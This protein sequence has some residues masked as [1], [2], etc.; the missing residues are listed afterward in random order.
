MILAEEGVRALCPPIRRDEPAAADGCVAKLFPWFS[1]PSLVYILNIKVDIVITELYFLP[2][3]T[4]NG[5]GD[6]VVFFHTLRGGVKERQKRSPFPDLVNAIT[7][8]LAVVVALPRL[9]LKATMHLGLKDEGCCFAF[10]GACL[11]SDGGETWPCHV[12]TAE[13]LVKQLNASKSHVCQVFFHTLRLRG[14]LLVALCR[15]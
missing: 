11:K 10:W 12:S 3:H 5:I 13:I 7:K 15:C 9:P 6:P 8:S 14:G 2:F 1:Y 4:V